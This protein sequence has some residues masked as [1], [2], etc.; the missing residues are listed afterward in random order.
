MD[1]NKRETDRF[2][3]RLIDILYYPHNEICMVGGVAYFES[4]PSRR[5]VVSV[6]MGERQS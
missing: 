6:G 3:Q 1:E 4:Q 5:A 2:R